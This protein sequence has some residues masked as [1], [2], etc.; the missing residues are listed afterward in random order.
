MAKKTNAIVC[1]VCGKGTLRRRRVDHEVGELLGLPGVTLR[2]AP[3][4]VCSKCGE[5][6]VDGAVLER[7]SLLLAAR[8]L[9]Q[10]ELAPAEIRYL[11]K[12]LGY[13]QEDL[14]A[15]LEVTRATV[16]RWE[17]SKGP[18][19]GPPAY[20]VRSHVF[21]R[22]R[23]HPAIAQVA[24]AFESPGPRHKGRYTVEGRSLAEAG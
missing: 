8:I 12:L 23:S 16:N 4:W 22:L 21:F 15:K 14:A 24:P 10:S 18:V 3:A 5:V 7:V 17:M 6:S 11:R 2:D 1:S 13:R 20:A 9:E 19:T